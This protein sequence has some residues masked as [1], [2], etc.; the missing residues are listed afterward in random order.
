MLI[1]ASCDVE[2]V[3]RLK[4]FFYFVLGF[5]FL[6]FAAGMGISCFSIC[7]GNSDM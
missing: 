3:R 4:D 1:P 2:G 7:D 5:G 6:G